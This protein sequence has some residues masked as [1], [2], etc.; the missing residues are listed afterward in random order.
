MYFTCLIIFLFNVRATEGTAVC[1]SGL[2][3]FLFN[4][5]ATEGTAV[6]FSGLII[7][8]FN[9]GVGQSGHLEYSCMFFWSD[10]I[11]LT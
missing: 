5:R 7:F 4:V 1:F 10:Y 2:I 9:V 3:I 11:F 8:L 6:C